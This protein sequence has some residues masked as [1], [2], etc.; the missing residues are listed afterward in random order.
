[1][2]FAIGLVVSAVAAFAQDPREIVRRSVEKDDLNEK[3]ARSY[4]FL[5]RREVHDSRKPTRIETWDVT[6]LEGTPYRRLV[7]R[8]DKPLSD[9]DREREEQKLQKNLADRRN[10]TPALRAK[11]LADYQRKQD[12]QRTV[13]R[14]IPDAWDF[15]LVREEA[16]GPVQAY[17][18]EATPHR[19]Y[20][21]KTKMGKYFAKFK[22]VFWIAKNDYTW[23]KIDAECIDPVTFGL[24]LFKVDRG[25]HFMLEQARVNDEVWLPKRLSLTAA[26]RLLFRRIDF[27]QE[28]IFSNYRKFLVESTVTPGEVKPSK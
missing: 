5:E 1:M 12:E 22:G 25:A 23:L 18:M 17:V 9:A 8:N 13:F 2:K 15:K 14:E 7:E 10:E 24:F 20:Q 16:Y 11:R 28:T 27:K 4:T 26:A 19:G 6:L 3:V 21:A